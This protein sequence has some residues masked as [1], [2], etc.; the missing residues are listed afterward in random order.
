MAI[1]RLA[2]LCG[3]TAA[4]AGAGLLYAWIWTT[5]GRGLPCLFHLFTGLYCPG[6]GVSRMCLRLLQGDWYGALR[7]NAALLVLSPAGLV[8]AARL[9]ARYVR[10][11]SARPSRGEEK[12]IWALAALLALF[13]VGRNLPWLAV[14]APH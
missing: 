3:W 11:G 13:G 10:T 1:K 8:L 12:A 7:A 9:C 6:C 5:T 14:L 4:L 2:R